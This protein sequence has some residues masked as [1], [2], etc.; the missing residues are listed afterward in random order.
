MQVAKSIYILKNVTQL[1]LIL[2][3]NILIINIVAGVVKLQNKVNL[4]Y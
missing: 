4:L 3:I 1:D 2:I